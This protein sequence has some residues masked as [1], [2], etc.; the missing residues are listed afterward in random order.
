MVLHSTQFA[1]CTIGLES[2]ETDAT[3]IATLVGESWDA[4]VMP[5]ITSDV[6]HVDTIATPLDGVSAGAIVDSEA[7]GTDGNPSV[8]DQVALIVTLRTALAGRAFRGRIYVPG[9]SNQDVDADPSQWKTG[10][11]SDMQGAMEAFKSDLATGDATWGVLSRSQSAMT[12]ITAVSV[13]RYITTQRRRLRG[14]L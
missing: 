12:P 14:G 11:V 6:R 5:Q 10:P 8:P 1:E 9:M 2:L 3:A 4:N 13:R 7:V